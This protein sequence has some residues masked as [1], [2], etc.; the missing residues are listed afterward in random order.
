MLC[1]FLHETGVHLCRLATVRKLIPASMIAGEERCG[2]ARYVECPAFRGQ[3]TES[4]GTGAC[5]YLEQPLVQFCAAAP[6]AQFVPWS[7][8]TA[9][10]CLSSA[11]HYCDVYLDVSGA[12]VRRV[13]ATGS[14]VD[15]GEELAVPTR[16]R[17]SPNHTWLDVAE[18]G[19]CHAGIDAL[20]ARLLGVVE[21]V[22]FL[23]PPGNG[24]RGKQ[25]PAAVLRAA[26]HDW[27]VAFPQRMNITACNPCLRTHPQRVSEDPYG[28]GWIFAGTGAETEG[29]M[30][31]EE[32]ATAMRNEARR[33]NELIQRGS[34]VSADGGMFEAGLLGKL[35]RQQAW[36]VFND[37]LAG[38]GR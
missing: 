7:E 19:V 21:S 33:L 37:L 22:E 1:P 4:A 28:R 32:A 13:P 38:P 35:P 23:T 12:P 34:G 26:G 10:R 6:V 17:Y 8:S 27:Q 30:P 31:A 9:S 36:Q 2:S 24:T 20:L 16:L 5:P 14:E 3:A 25:M 18:D 11:F 29:T 15:G